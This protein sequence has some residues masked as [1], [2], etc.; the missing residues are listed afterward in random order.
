M[1]EHSEELISM[2]EH[3][4]NLISKIFL[5]N[6]EINIKVNNLVKIILNELDELTQNQNE[7]RNG[8]SLYFTVHPSFW[9][10]KIYI[11]VN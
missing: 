3:I 1:E 7:T 4:T 8:L 9:H 11:G 6:I 2:T 5:L 10:T